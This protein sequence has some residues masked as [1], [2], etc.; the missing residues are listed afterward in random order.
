[1]E[2]LDEKTTQT[3]SKFSV[4]DV[5]LIAETKLNYVTDLDST[6]QLALSKVT[7]LENDPEFTNTSALDDLKKQIDIS[8]GKVNDTLNML[9]TIASYSL[10]FNSVV[11]KSV[12][13]KL[14]SGATLSPTLQ[15]A[16]ASTVEKLMDIR[17]KLS[18]SGEEEQAKEEDLIPPI[19]DVQA[20][21]TPVEEAQVEENAKPDE[22]SEDLETIKTKVKSLSKRVRALED[23]IK[24][25]TYCGLGVCVITLL[26]LIFAIIS[27][28]K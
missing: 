27:L 19:S 16:I 1:M 18:Q 3:I 23:K 8:Q 5:A 7:E 26:S 9:T 10:D 22:P 24:L 4:D 28:A 2:L 13:Q 12:H 25:F 14:T 20:E 15:S 11:I 21:E 17:Q 6:I